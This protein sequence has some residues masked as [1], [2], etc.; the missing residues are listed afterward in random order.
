VTI[1][2]EEDEATFFFDEPT[3][4][5]GHWNEAYDDDDEAVI[6]YCLRFLEHLFADRLVVS[7]SWDRAMD[8]SFPVTESEK[9]WLRTQK[10]P[11]SYAATGPKCSTT[12]AR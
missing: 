8:Y 5:H 6:D 10:R 3:A 12:L 1:E 11:G 9:E 2:V 7:G 4:A